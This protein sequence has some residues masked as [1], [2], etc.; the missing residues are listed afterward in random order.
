M[1]KD[2]KCYAVLG[3][4]FVYG[5]TLIPQKERKRG[6]KKERKKEHCGYLNP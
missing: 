1:F 6:R 5:K 3:L 2:A 4:E